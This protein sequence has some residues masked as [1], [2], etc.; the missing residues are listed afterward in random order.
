MKLFTLTH[1]PIKDRTVLLRTD[2]NVPL[3]DGKVID[4][5]RIKASLETINFLLQNNCKIIIITHL[6]RPEGKPVPELK[7]NPIAEELKRLLSGRYTPKVIKL[8][9]CIGKEIKA[10]IAAGNGGDIFL[11]ENLRF[12]KGEEENNPAFAHSLAELADIYINEAFSNSHRKHASMHS[13]T[14][15]LPALPGISLEKE[16]AYFSR[17]L[18]P[19]R[20]AVWIIGGSKLDKADFIRQALQKAD[21]ILIGGAL[22][23]SFLKAKNI[24]IG[25]SKTDKDSAEIAR[26]LLKTDKTKK[27]IFPRD[28][29]VADRFASNANAQIVLY[30]QIQREQIGLDLGPETIKL[31]KHFL[32]K[33]H[34]IV[35][36]GPLGKFEWARF[37][38]ATREIGRFIGSLTAASI[39]GGGETAEAIYKFHLEHKLTHVSTGGGAALMFLSGK[40][41]PGIEALEDNYKIFRKK[42]LEI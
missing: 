10:K 20:P 5:T 14:K 16:I 12:Y 21:Y 2:F 1:F 11:L 8:N 39:C 18:E 32:R 4:N 23:F 17:A 27:L 25:M 9:D 40:K 26:K 34:T 24:P 42:L 30:N 3:K 28:F 13:V 31:F 22:A 41:L 33:A 19:K 37:S 38:T 15:F 29:V 36:N 35:W 7:L 6:G